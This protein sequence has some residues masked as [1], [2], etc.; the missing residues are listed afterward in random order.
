LLTPLGDPLGE[1]VV[2]TSRVNALTGLGQVLTGAFIVL[3]GTWWFAN[4]H[5][6]RTTDQAARD[7]ASAEATNLWSL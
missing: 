6:R 7:D 5:K 2:L 4:W 3:L 1:P